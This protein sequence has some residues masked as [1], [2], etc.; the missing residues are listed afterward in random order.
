MREYESYYNNRFRQDLNKFFSSIPDDSRFHEDRE[1]KQIFS[2]QYHCLTMD[3]GHLNFLSKSEKEY[4]GVALYFTVLVD[5]VCYSDFNQFYNEFQKL[6]RYPKFIGNC[7][8]AC[9]I[10]FHPSEIFDAMNSRAP[11]TNEDNVSSKLVFK[12][13]FLEAIPIMKWETLD[14]F[15]NHLKEI[16]GCVF[17][18]RCEEE[19]LYR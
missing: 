5:M 7:L 19:F 11:L 18:E 12:D 6:T 8:S 14:F 13:V 15:S 4:F 3:S 10:H 1:H 2:V 17:W 16:D 9:R